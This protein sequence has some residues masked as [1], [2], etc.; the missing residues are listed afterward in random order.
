[1]EVES[2][3]WKLKYEELDAQMTL[4]IKELKKQLTLKE[5]RLV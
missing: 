1:V 4:K 3:K 2:G 5:E